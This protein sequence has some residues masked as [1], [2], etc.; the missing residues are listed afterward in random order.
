MFRIAIIIVIIIVLVWCSNLTE[1]F[2]ETIGIASEPEATDKYIYTSG[3]SMR[4]MGQSFSS[5]NQ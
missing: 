2:G 3:A 4:V 1:K 5:T